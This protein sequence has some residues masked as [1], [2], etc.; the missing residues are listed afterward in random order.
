METL[1]E[2]NVKEKE[3]HRQS[4]ARKRAVEKAMRDAQREEFTALRTQHESLL[5]A[6]WS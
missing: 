5:A 4:M 2:R 3:R 6:Y 1:E